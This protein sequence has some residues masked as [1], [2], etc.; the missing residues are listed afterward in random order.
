MTAQQRKQQGEARDDAGEAQRF[1]VGVQQRRGDRATYCRR[2]LNIMSVSRG[3][4]SA[5]RRQR[6]LQ[7][8]NK[9]VLEESTAHHATT[10]RY[11]SKT[12]Y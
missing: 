11:Q 7:V 12:P 3:A 8:S 2:C 6:P 10:A 5:S 1:V 4:R 9:T